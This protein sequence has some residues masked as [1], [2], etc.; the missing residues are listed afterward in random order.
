MSD[1]CNMIITE[2][3]I[4]ELDL[5]DFMAALD[6]LE[7]CN[8]PVEGI[9]DVSDVQKKLRQTLIKAN[10]IDKFKVCLVEPLC[11]WCSGYYITY[12]PGTTKTYAHAFWGVLGM[13]EQ[14]VIQKRDRIHVPIYALKTKSHLKIL[15]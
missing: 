7:Q 11:I 6:V 3:A 1:K 10:K 2:E 13:T 12:I 9:N 14:T 5:D 4:N 8:I 15:F